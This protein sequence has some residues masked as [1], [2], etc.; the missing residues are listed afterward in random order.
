MAISYA[1]FFQPTVLGAGASVLYTVP[2]QPMSNLFRGGRVRFTNTTNAAASVTAHAVPAA[3]TAGAGNAFLSGITV[4]ANSY[5]DSD[6]P[7]MAAGDTLQALCG[8]AAT[9]TAHAVLGGV[10]SS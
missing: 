8:T 10:S 3:G 1:K 4:P 5:V 2:A 6:V 7:I 9:I